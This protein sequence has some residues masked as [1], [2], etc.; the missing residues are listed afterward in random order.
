MGQNWTTKE[1]F[2]C[3]YLEKGRINVNANANVT[4]K[5]GNGRMKFETELAKKDGRMADKNG[6][7]NE[8]KFRRKELEAFF[9]HSYY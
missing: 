9:G 1:F 3:K 2:V 4:I 5:R 7:I 6:R 8:Q